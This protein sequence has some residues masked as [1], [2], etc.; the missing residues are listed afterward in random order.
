M[1]QLSESYR[2]KLHKYISDVSHL[3]SEVLKCETLF[4]I[5]GFGYVDTVQESEFRHV[6]PKP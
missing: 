3:S 4:R 5:Q 1:T 2:E 6:E